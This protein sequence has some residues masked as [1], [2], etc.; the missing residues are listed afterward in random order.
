MSIPELAC[1]GLEEAV[2]RFLELD[3]TAQKQLAQL[4]GKAIAFE[5][6]GTGQTLYLI[7]DPARLQVFSRYEGEPDCLLRGTP[8]ALTRM[9]DQKTSSGQLFSGEVEITGDTELAHSFGKILGS[10]DID[11]EEQLSHYTGDVV[12]HGVGDLIRGA[13]RWGRNTLETFG[14]DLQEYLQEELR[15]LPQRQEIETFLSDVDRL[16]DDVERLEARLQRL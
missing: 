10:M 11:W 3:P 15:L 8:L 13:T 1:A 2:N 6:S 7:P 9:G 4:H 12:A 14:M 5:V 16:R